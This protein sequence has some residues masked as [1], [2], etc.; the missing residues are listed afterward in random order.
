MD[1]GVCH[2]SLHGAGEQAQ[3][4]KMVGQK[5]G[6]GQRASS[7]LVNKLLVIITETALSFSLLFVCFFKLTAC[8]VFHTSLLLS[9]Y[10][11]NVSL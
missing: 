9:L 10:E 6:R 4:G 5:G 11:V 8:T 1:G 7:S 2:R 3:H